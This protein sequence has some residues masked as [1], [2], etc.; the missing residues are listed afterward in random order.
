MS[1]ESTIAEDRAKDRID[2][3]AKD[4]V[5]A[6]QVLRRGVAMS[7]QL[8]RGLPVIVAVGVFAAVGRLIVPVLVQLV[9]DHG[10][11]GDDGYRPGVVWVL[12][13]FALGLV[14]VVASASRLALIKMVTLAESVML[15]LRV[16]A[17]EHI[18]RL[19]LAD[20]SESRRGVLVARVTSDIE[21]MA[22]FMQWG[23]M[24]WT[25]NPVLIV[26]TL[27]VM[28]FYSWQ[29][30]LLVLVLH[31]LLI[32][33]LRWIQQR[34]IAAHSLVRDRVAETLGHASESVSGAAVIRAYGYGPA[35]RR[36]LDRAVDDQYRSQLSAFKWWA[37]MLPVVDLVSAVALAASIVVG[38][39]WSEEL[40]IGAGSLV[41]FVFLVRLLIRPI[42][43]LG[44]VFDTTQSALAAWWKVL[45]VL[46][47]PVEVVEPSTETAVELPS[48]P[49]SIEARSVDFSYRAPTLV[50]RG[51]EVS[52]PSGTKVAVVGETGSGKTTFARLL[53]RLADPTAGEILIGGLN[54]REVAAHSRRRGIRLVPQDGFLFAATIEDNIRFGRSGATAAEAQAAID[55]LGLRGW[56]ETLPLGIKTPVG[57]RG[58]RLSVGE[59]QLVALARAQVADPGLLIL[60]EATSAVDP[61][62]E[63]AL[64]AAVARLAQGR[65]VLSIAHRLS[66][67]ERADLVLVFD[68]GQITEQGTHHQLLAAGGGYAKLHHRWVSNTRLAGPVR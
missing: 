23:A 3:R 39:T 32:P 1:S 55:A 5:K 11:L 62:T 27:T 53:T 67:A 4:R 50:L 38:V 17:F 20:H 16:R 56:L 9:L 45:G 44:E 58:G 19:S 14:L 18:H 51:V 66:T 30:T 2:D 10:V 22:V 26:G 61:E 31:L 46:D 63:E 54:L 40:G 35:V 25:I 41:A 49:L 59:R 42:S 57:Q 21:A 33:F 43:E 7:K 36:R 37:V 13:L 34:Q 12:A 60:D 8:R 64:T 15:D 52:I 47:T 29:L 48:G 6:L 28:L 65:T 68:D 24:S